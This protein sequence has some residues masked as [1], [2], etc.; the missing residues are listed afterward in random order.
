[1]NTVAATRR[2]GQLEAANIGY[3]G[4]NYVRRLAWE[5][6]VVF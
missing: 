4:F 6:V 5:L 2:L 1:M 3:T